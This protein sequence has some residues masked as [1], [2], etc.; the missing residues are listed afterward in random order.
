MDQS[1]WVYESA[2][3]LEYIGII[4]ELCQATQDSKHPGTI[5][6]QEIPPHLSH[7]GRNAIAQLDVH[8]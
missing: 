5:R 6:P 1:E 4:S 2:L 8:I 3:L 7:P